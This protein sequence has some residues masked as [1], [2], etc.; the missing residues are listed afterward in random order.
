MSAEVR[1]FGPNLRGN[2]ETFHVH[3]AGCRD[4]RNYGPRGRLGGDHGRPETFESLQELIEEWYG[5]QIAE[6]EP[7]SPWATWEGYLDEFRVFPCVSFD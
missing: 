5:D 1:V 3:A 4:C 6:Q 7:G 2:T